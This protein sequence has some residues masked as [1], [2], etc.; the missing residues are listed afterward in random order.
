MDSSSSSSG[1][2]AAGSHLYSYT[3]ATLAANTYTRTYSH[4]CSYAD[5]CKHH[6][7]CV[8]YGWTFTCNCPEG[9]CGELSS[10]AMYIVCRVAPLGYVPTVSSCC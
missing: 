9:W 7:R 6:G 4:P 5:A 10:A 8:P 1:S 3:G 2:T